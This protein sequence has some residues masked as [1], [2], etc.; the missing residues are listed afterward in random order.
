LE[1]GAQLSE[2]L[3]I[4][5]GEDSSVTL[6]FKAAEK[7]D[8]GGPVDVVDGKPRGQTSMERIF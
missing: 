5:N 6:S 3:R 4:D 7:L 1:I 2:E 8:N